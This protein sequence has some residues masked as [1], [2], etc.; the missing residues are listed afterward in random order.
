MDVFSYQ[1]IV[2]V[3]QIIAIDVLLGGDNAVVIAL[4]CR[5]L[6]EQQRKKGILWG[7]AGAIM[8]RIALIFCALKLLLL[9]FL[10]IAG[11][12]LLI[13]IGI[14]LLQPEE[15]D[16]HESID[17][18]THL[19]GA[20]KTIIIADAVMSM[21]NVIAVAAAAKGELGLVSF[22]ILISVPIIV[23]GSS[24]VLKLMDRFP[25]VITFGGGLLG[26]IAGGMLVTDV[27]LTA[28]LQ[29]MPGWFHHAA[30]ALGALLV[31][32]IGKIMVGRGRGTSAVPLAELTLAE[33]AV[34]DAAKPEP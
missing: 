29:G 14:K 26:W 9:P 20:I 2:S 34:D 4:A 11:A 3:L 27:W 30:S 7:V 31:V 32:V 15:G 33:A 19:I 22:G 8:L 5:R 1:Y 17:G 13:W 24:I 23:W 6:P 10:K 21:D 18:S 25:A 12:L 16:G 28:R